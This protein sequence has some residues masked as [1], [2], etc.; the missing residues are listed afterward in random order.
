MTASPRS[1][2]PS[3]APSGMVRAS[4]ASGPK[5]IDQQG[6]PGHEGSLRKAGPLRDLYEGIYRSGPDQEFNSLDAQYEAASAYIKSQAHAGSN[7]SLDCPRTTGSRPSRR[8]R[9]FGTRRRDAKNRRSG[10]LRLVETKIQEMKGRKS[11]QKAP[12]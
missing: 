4:L 3:R 12:E 5:R 10:A 1:P 9:N 8:E 11:P 2:S 6:R 7:L